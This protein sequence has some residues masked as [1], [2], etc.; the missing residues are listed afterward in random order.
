MDL[1]GFVLQAD[2]ESY[3]VPPVMIIAGDDDEAKHLAL[4]PAA[5]LG[6]D[7]I[8]A[9]P[10]RLARLLERPAMPAIDRVMA[11]GAPGNDAFAFPHRE[12]W[13]A[14]M[15]RPGLCEE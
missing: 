13:R 6:F 10:L 11:H 12:R 8:D 5:V 3:F 7:A 1:A 15:R 4:R 2:A 9:G 14:G